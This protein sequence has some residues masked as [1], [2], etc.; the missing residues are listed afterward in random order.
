MLAVPRTAG[1]PVERAPRGRAG[2]RRARGGA[3]R[4]RGAGR[5][6]RRP[7]SSSRAAPPRPT[8]WRCAASL[9][10][11]RPARSG[12]DGDRA[13]LGARDGAR[14]SRPRASRSRVVRVDARRARRRRP[15][16]SRRAT[17]AT[18]LVSVGLANGE[19]GTRGAGG[20]D[21][22]RRSRAAASLAAHRRRAGGR[23]AAGR[24]ARARRRS[25]LALG[26]Q[27]RRSGRRRRALGAA[28]ACALAP[29]LDRRPAGARAARRHREPSPAIVGFGAA[30]RAAR[31]RAA[32]TT[33]ARMAALRERLWHG[34]PRARARTSCGNGP[35]AAPRLPN[36]LNVQLPRLRRREPARAARPRR[37]RG[38]RS[39]RRAP[40]AR[41]SRRTCCARWGATPRRRA[42]ALRLSLGPDDHRGR[43]RP[44]AR[45]AAARSSRQVRAG[46]ARVARWRERVVVAMSGGVDSAVAAARCVAAGLRRVGISLRL[47][48]DGGGQLLLARRLP[49]RAR[50][51]RP[52]RHPALRLRLAATPSSARVV[53]AVRRRVPGRADAEPVRALQPAREV[54]PA[55]AA[56]P[57]AGRAPPRDR[58]LRAHRRRPG[59]RSRPRC[60]PRSTP[61]RTRRYFLFALDAGRAGA[62]RSSRSASSPRREVRAEAA[63]ARPPGRRQAGEHGGVL[64]PRRRRGRRSSSAHAPP[65]GAAARGRSSTRTGAS[66]GAPRRR[67]PLHGRPAPRPRAR[68][69][70]A[71]ATCA[72]STRRPGTVTVGD[73]RR[74]SARAGSWRARSSWAPGAPPAAGTRARRPHPPPPS[75]RRRRGS[76]TATADAARVAL[77][78]AR[79]RR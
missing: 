62:A 68:R 71:R 49:R 65:G 48:R 54:R 8:T 6:A 19:V 74:A 43:D 35:A 58:A 32:R 13:R 79:A 28:A 16:W 18:A 29:Q 61:R 27:A 37:R 66:V 21:R 63:R 52:A 7:R 77:R 31:A 67:A 70:A 17:P 56:R 76:P 20:G 75:A 72:R 36:T 60:A 2:A 26:A 53:R 73:A 46:A 45:P 4:G 41:P 51:R 11:G 69:R 24:R 40:P 34:P 1:E 44:R 50:G 30:A 23:A 78:R 38:R 25:P 10:R 9:G 14:R 3:R 47:A 57:R 5:R 33:A 42:A 12:H 15:T 55:L 22:R 64:R 59:D 39:A